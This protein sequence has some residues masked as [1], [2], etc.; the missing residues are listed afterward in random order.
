MAERLGPNLSGTVEGDTLVLRIKLT[1]K[2]RTSGS[3]KSKVLAK[4]A[5]RVQFLDGLG[6]DYSNYGLIL[7][8][9]RAKKSKSKKR[10]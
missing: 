1:N 9:F 8:L 3:G 2:G 6:S 7:N 10:K 4:T 5:D